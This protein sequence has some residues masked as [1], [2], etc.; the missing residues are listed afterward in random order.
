MH[1]AGS[2]LQDYFSVDKMVWL[3]EYEKRNQLGLGDQNVEDYYN[4]DKEINDF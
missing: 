2:R 4:I 3:L 1:P